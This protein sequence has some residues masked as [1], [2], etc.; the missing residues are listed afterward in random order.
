MKHPKHKVINNEK[1]YFVE[2]IK[3]FGFTTESETMKIEVRN[4]LHTIK[5]FVLYSNLN[6][7]LSYKKF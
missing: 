1:P 7:F 3:G 4:L 2:N 6:N 5:I